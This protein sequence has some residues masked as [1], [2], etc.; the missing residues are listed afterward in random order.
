MAA[1][2]KNSLPLKKVL[3]GVATLALLYLAKTKWTKHRRQLQLKKQGVIKKKSLH[4][5]K[6]QCFPKVKW[7]YSQ[8]FVSETIPPPERGEM[9]PGHKQMKNH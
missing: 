2:S 9:F 7:A 3:V 5:T 6:H 4:E 1:S 8:E